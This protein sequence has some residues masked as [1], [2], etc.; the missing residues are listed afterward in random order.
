MSAAL[1]AMQKFRLT[2][3]EGMQQIDKNNGIV[4]KTVH[5]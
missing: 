3:G 5:P 1:R 2:T 4:K